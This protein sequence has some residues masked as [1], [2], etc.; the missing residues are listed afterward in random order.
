MPL[1]KIILIRSIGIGFGAMLAIIIFVLSYSWYT[2][3]PRPWDTKSITSTFDR[4]LTEGDDN[5]Y[6]FSYIIQNN[7]NEDYTLTKG[8]DVIVSAKLKRQNSIST[9]NE[10]ESNIITDSPVFAPAKQK[11]YF[12][13]HINYQSKIKPPNF[14]NETEFNKYREA[15]KNELSRNF[16]NIDGFMIY[17]KTRKYQIDLPRGW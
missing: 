2:S 15:V 17:D 7:T 10:N 6:V 1:W 8:S 3:R 9:D 14:D 11:S 13:V 12:K 5:T 16:K 4:V